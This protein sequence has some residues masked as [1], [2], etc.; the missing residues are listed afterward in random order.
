MWVSLSPFDK[1]LEPNSFAPLALSLSRSHPRERQDNYV[2][3]PAHGACAWR[4]E[5]NGEEKKEER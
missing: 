5:W 2:W 4:M 1:T 3:G